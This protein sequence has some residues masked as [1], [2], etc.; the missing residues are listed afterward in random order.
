MSNHTSQND[1]PH[2]AEQPSASAPKRRLSVVRLLIAAVTTGALIVGGVIG[3]QWWAAAATASVKP[4]FAGYADVTATPTFNFE[5][6]ASKAGRDV[7]LSFIVGASDGSCTPTWGTAFTLDQAAVSLDLDRKIARLEQQGGAVAISFGGQRNNELATA[8][9]DVGALAAAYAQVI[10][11]YHISTIDLDIEGANLSNPAVGQRRAEAIKKLQ[12]TRRAAGKPLAVWLTLP[13]SPSGLSV[14]GQTA[15]SQML[16]TGVD[17]A[18]V[19]AMTMDYGS[20]R[21]AGQSM[22]TA[23]T[24]ALTATQ[25]QLKVLYSRAGVHLSDATVWAKLGATPMIGQND[26]PGE[27]FDLTTAKQLNTFVLN[28]GIGRVSMWSLNRDIT[29][30]PNYVDVTQVSDACSGVNQGKQKFADLLAADLTGRLTLAAKAVTTADPLGPKA[31]ADD[32]AT[33]PYPI[34]SKTSAYLKGTKIVWHHNVYVAKW[35]TRGDLPDNPVLNA[36]ET[37]WSLIGPVLPGEKPLPLPT[38]PAGTYPEWSGE[39]VYQKG[40][41]VLDNGVPYEA[42][43]WNQGNSPD[44]ASSNPDSSPWAPLTIKQIEAVKAGK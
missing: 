26:V 28:H 15:V 8:C 32:P 43:W 35:W 2:Q 19:N 14:E 4:W 6:P 13:V 29:C 38:L 25:R 18:G 44:A 37:P 5:S 30:G 36:W 22:L 34:W 23:T 39:A 1:H 21:V 11:R 33:S 42:K 27:V 17:L 20:S 9:T 31:A 41:R 16:A 12:S 24:D 10:D 3:Y 7:F 40:A